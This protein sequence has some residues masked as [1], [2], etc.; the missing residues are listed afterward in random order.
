MKINEN[1]Q[2]VTR[3]GI[4]VFLMTAA[5]ALQSK[6]HA[7]EKQSGTNIGIENEISTRTSV[8][9]DSKNTANAVGGGA[10]V[11]SSFSGSVGPSSSTSSVSGLSS[12]SSTG[13]IKNSAGG[14]SV[15]LN[16]QYSGNKYPNQAPPIYTSTSPSFS[17]RNCQAVGSAAASG[18]FG[19]ISAAFG[20]N[21]DTCD[22]ENL[23]DILNQWVQET[24]DQRLWEVNCNNLVISNDNLAEAFEKSGYSCH[25]AYVNKLAKINARAKMDALTQ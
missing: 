11:N 6:A 22:A 4:T 21:S 9:V 7:T 23:A 18:P 17:Q 3:I 2:L 10:F 19:G 15:S 12:T 14:A 20:L 1:L 8:D 25:D 5:M 16:Q 24:G 13:A